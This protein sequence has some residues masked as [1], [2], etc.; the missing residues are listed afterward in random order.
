[1]YQGRA[2]CDDFDAGV[3]KGYL[4][5]KVTSVMTSVLKMKCECNDT[6]FLG[7]TSIRIS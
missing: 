7:L 4:W 3:M 2:Q 6:G 5:L 1:M